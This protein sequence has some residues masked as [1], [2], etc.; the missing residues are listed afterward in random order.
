MTKV[1]ISIAFISAV[2]A[3]SS[4]A[5]ADGLGGQSPSIAAGDLRADKWGADGRP[6]SSE[7]PPA[8][9]VERKGEPAEQAVT[10]CERG[11]ICIATPNLPEASKAENY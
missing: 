2:A 8:V 11:K 10:L 6:F 4:L 3:A 7:L 5:Y 9:Q 1:T